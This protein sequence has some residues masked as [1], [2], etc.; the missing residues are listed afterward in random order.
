MGLD[1]RQSVAAATEWLANLTT[2]KVLIAV[3]VMMLALAFGRLLSRTRERGDDWISENVQVVLSVVVVVFLIIRPYLFQ[4]FYIP[5]GSMEPTLMGPSDGSSEGI[6][7]RFGHTSRQSSGDRLLVNKLVYRV[8]DPHRLDIA[9]FRAPVQ[10]SPDEKEFIKRVIGLPG[11]T[12][13]VVP[14]QVE[15]DGHAAVRLSTEGGM[16]LAIDTEDIASKIKGNTVDLTGYSGVSFKLLTLSNPSLNADPYQVQVDGKPELQDALGRIVSKHSLAEYGGDPALD[17]TLF[18]IDNQPR[19]AVVRGKTLRYSQG[20]VTVNG[21]SWPETYIKEAPKYVMAPRKLGPHEYFMMG[22]NRNNS[23]DSHMWGPLDR[24]RFI[25]RAEILFWPFYRIR[26]FKW[27]LI[28][29]IAGL[30]IGYQLVYRFL[31]GVR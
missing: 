31:S 28:S 11:E 19:L 10:A 26:I 6:A 1:L 5:S 3:G 17:A 21:K 22:D 23:N 30:M 24:S 14:P 7:D 13:E 18:T 20:H 8:S 16:G 25:G 15:V 4:A 27:W 12:V 29:A 9:V 2:A